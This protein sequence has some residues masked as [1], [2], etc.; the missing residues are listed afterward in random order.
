MC[1]VLETD[2]CRVM[3][4][5]GSVLMLLIEC[6]DQVVL[7]APHEDAEAEWLA[8]EFDSTIS[9]STASHA[10]GEADPFP[11]DL[12]ALDE[13]FA[14][15]PEKSTR[16]GPNLKTIAVGLS[17]AVTSVRLEPAEH[18]PK[19]RSECVARAARRVAF[20]A[21]AEDRVVKVPLRF[22]L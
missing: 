7:P 13:G 5:A 9:A 17:G 6:A 14:Q 10:D 18:A 12:R 3:N 1:V 4:C 16:R 8:A 11:A 15:C 22:S 19:E 20:P 21:S 2:S